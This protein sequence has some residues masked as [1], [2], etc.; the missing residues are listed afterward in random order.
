MKPKIFTEKMSALK[1][2]I[3]TF[4]KN[5]DLNPSSFCK[6]TNLSPA[7]IH[8]ILNAE[9]PNPTIETVLEIS[10]VMNCSL[11]DL[12]D[13]NYTPRDPLKLDNTELLKSVCI[14]ICNDNAIHGKS[15]SEFFKAIKDV[16]AYCSTN[17]LKTSDKNF[18]SWYLQNKQS[19]H[20]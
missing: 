6:N 17:N 7:A 10:K 5:K 13:Q 3:I 19:I 9:V 14:T 12:F 18:V 20:L 4:I 8:N 2:K 16:Y 11:D 1:E 15:F